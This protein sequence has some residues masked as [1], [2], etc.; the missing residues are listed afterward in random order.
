MIEC[1]A[2][3]NRWTKDQYDREVLAEARGL[4]DLMTDMPLG[5][6]PSC[7]EDGEVEA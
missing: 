1:K 6:C 3:G 4:D 5:W 7:G 2:C